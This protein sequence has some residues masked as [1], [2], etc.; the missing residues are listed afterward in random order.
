MGDTLTR[1]PALLTSSLLA[2][3]RPGV[4]LFVGEGLA[5]SVPRRRPRGHAMARSFA[6]R[7]RAQ[8][9]AGGKAAIAEARCPAVV[10]VRGVLEQRASFW[11]C[12]ESCGY[13]ELEMR[14]CEALVDPGVSALVI[15]LDSP[16]GDGPG[17]EQCIA[18]VRALADALGKL[19]LGYVNELA[20]SAGLWILAGLCDAIYLP[21]SGRAGSV[22]CLVPFIGEAR[23]LRREGLDVYIARAPAGKARPSSVEGLDPIGK[24]RID[25]LAAEGE[26]RFVAAI[27]TRRHLAPEVIRGWNG[28]IFTGA[29]AVSAGIADGVAVAGLDTVIALAAEM[30]AQ[31]EAA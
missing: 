25:A 20:A 14:L 1:Q 21:P 18:K 12:G 2:S 6:L 3:V 17:L 15:D 16:G 9:G 28:G 8:V 27:A 24:A 13:D 29:A 4:Q 5:A 7:P 23:A 19:I 31:R 22:G 30:G 11:S 26:A 10:E